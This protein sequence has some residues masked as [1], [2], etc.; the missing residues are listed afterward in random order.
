MKIKHLLINTL[1]DVIGCAFFALPLYFV[2][3]SMR[4]L[5]KL[6]L[7]LNYIDVFLIV[8]SFTYLID[9]ARIV[10]EIKES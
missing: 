3:I 4:F 2:F 7:D 5:T 10:R 6:N 8:W 9:V 1:I